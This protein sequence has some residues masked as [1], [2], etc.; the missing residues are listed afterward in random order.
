MEGGGDSIFLLLLCLEFLAR[1]PAANR[2]VVK[3][4]SERH[5]PNKTI[6]HRLCDSNKFVAVVFFGLCSREIRRWEESSREMSFTRADRSF[7]PCRVYLK[8]RESSSSTLH[9]I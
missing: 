8:S 5:R 6:R 2:K 3:S 1:C 9:A 4:P 7:S